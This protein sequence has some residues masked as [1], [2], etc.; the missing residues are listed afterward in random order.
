[1][2]PGAIVGELGML[3]P[4]L[5]R[6]QTVICTRDGSVLEIAYNRIEQLYHQN[7][8]FGFYF[9]RLSTQRLFDNIERLGRSLAERDSE[10]KRLRSMQSPCNINLGNEIHAFETLADRGASKLHQA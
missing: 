6:T 3:A 5:K 10:I 8:T 1:L 2:E 4:D 7:P 9:L